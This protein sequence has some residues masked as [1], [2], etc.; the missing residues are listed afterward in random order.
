MMQKAFANYV[1]G[2][3]ISMPRQNLRVR[4]AEYDV[5]IGSGFAFL[6]RVNTKIRVHAHLNESNRVVYG[7]YRIRSRAR[8]CP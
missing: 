8:C 2:R 7:Y 1:G 4:A 3:R 6:D 5:C